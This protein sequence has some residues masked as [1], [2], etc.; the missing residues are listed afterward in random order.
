MPSVP[1]AADRPRIQHLDGLRGIAIA[2]V[3]LHHVPPSFIPADPGTLSGYAAAALTLTYTG[4][5]LFFVLSGYL[6]GGIL[7]DHRESPRL[8]HAFYWRRAARILPLAAGCI[9]LGLGLHGLK[10]VAGEPWPA[11]V[12]LLFGTNL[13]M[14]AEGHWGFMPLAMLWSLA[15]EEQFY[16]VA[17]WIISRLPPERQPR[18]FASLV[19]AAPVSRWLILVIW[20][21]S[22]LAASLLP[23]CRMDSLGLGL[24]A[25][26]IV[27][28][29]A[30]AG[31]CRNRVWLLGGV[32]AVAA[33]GALYLS[34]IR[35]DNG[36][37]AMAWGGYTVVAVLYFAILLWTELHRES[38]V[39]RILCW[40]PLCELGRHSY[41]IYLFHG[42]VLS[43]AVSLIFRRTAGVAEPLN[44][45]Q[46]G[47]GLGVLFV[48]AALSWR[49]M[50][51]PLLAW[52]RRHTAY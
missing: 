49:W 48:L 13:L 39:A 40:R 2:L 6:I 30:A 23:F 15:I 19:I 14:A 7:L 12:Y 8:S 45:L 20:P 51:Q 36:G 41:F 3:L 4:V 5:D 11:A 22:H 27:R 47:P 21:G 25:A 34:R 44:W 35:A 26:W 50:E 9:A 31:W 10:L 32:F 43:L 37:A 33:A 42:M 38:P 29:Q 24:L 18:F 16:L 52:A 1:T 46:F 17:P 28:D